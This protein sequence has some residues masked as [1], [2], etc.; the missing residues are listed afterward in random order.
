MQRRRR[1]RNNKKTITILPKHV[2]FLLFFITVAII[3]VSYRFPDF[4]QPVRNGL[5]TVVTPMQ[6]GINSVGRTISDRFLVFENLKNG[7]I[8]YIIYLQSERKLIKTIFTHDFFL[9]K[10][11]TRCILLMSILWIFL[12]DDFVFVW[13]I[14]S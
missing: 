13:A 2:F 6:R 8:H 14:Q 10:Q 11:K 9:D 5:D 7:K 1:R 3:F 4:I 12:F